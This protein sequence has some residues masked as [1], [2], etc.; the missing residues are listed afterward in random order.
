[1]SLISASDAYFL[2]NKISLAINVSSLLVDEV[3]VVYN[4]DH[5]DEK[6]AL[7]KQIKDNYEKHYC[8]VSSSEGEDYIM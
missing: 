7:K 1:M 8:S 2:S 6:T 3:E 5:H 4:E